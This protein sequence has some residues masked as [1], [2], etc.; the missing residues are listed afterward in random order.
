MIRLFF[1]IFILSISISASSQSRKKILETTN[2]VIQSNW[3]NFFEM[4]SIPNDGYDTPNI[5]RNIEWCEL[6]FSRLG[7]NMERVKAESTS[8]LMPNHPLLIG[9]KFISNKFKTVLIY[10]H[11]DGQPVDPS[12]WNQADPFDPIL[13]KNINGRWVEI[14]R[15]RI[16]TN[17]DPDWRIFGRST[18]DDKGPPMMLVNALEILEKLNKKPEFNIKLIIDFQEEMG[19]PTVV[20][21]VSLYKEKLKSDF[22]LI[23]DGPRHPSNKPTLTFGARGIS[24]ITLTSYGPIKPQHSG[25]FGNYAPNPA[26]NLSKI[27]SSM[28]DYDGVV[29]IPGFYDGVTLTNEIRKILDEVPDDEEAINNDLLI[30]SPDKVG[31]NYQEAIQYPSLNVRGLKSGWVGKEARTIVPD[32]AIAEIDVRLVKESEPEKLLN[33]IKDHI[34]KEGA[35]VINSREPTNEERLTKKNIIRYDSK[36]SYL[37]YRTEINSPIGNWASRAL[38]N[39]F[40]EEPIKKRTSGGS[41]PISPFVTT[42]NVP[43]L[44]YPSVNKDNNQHSPNENIRVGNFIDGT[45]GM[46]YLLLEKI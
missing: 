42:L 11:M 46:V 31:N 41:I 3:N 28:K 4:L 44:T 39:A 34:I 20:S 23:I 45:L 24:R 35:Y 37:A 18:S 9:N 29:T 12:K 33:M 40:L 22:L 1:L 6:T 32:I 21:A 38:K 16:N 14:D 15:D 8:P 27:L 36:I 30:S 19:S 43:A 2:E 17:P 13:S 7:F 5:E 26:M 25:H 10:F